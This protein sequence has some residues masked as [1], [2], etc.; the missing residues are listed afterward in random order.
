MS[1]FNSKTEKYTLVNFPLRTKMSTSARQSQMQSCLSTIK[2]KHLTM[3]GLQPQGILIN[4][5]QLKEER[6][7][8]EQELEND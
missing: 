4:M 2:S 1:K 7:K 6:V 5:K 3:V 8:E